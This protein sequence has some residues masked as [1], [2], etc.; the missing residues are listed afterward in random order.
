MP[1]LPKTK[2][3]FDTRHT[4]AENLLNQYEYPHEVLV[5]IKEF[6]KDY[7]T[8]LDDSYEER[9]EGVFIAKNATVWPGAIIVGPAIIGHYAEIR[10]GAFV[11]GSVIVGDGAIIGN[12]T[13]VKNSII[14]D[15]ATLPHYNYVGDSIIGFKAHMGAGAIASNLRLDKREIVLGIGKERVQ[16]KLRKIGAFLG[17]CAEVGCGSILCP[18]TIIGKGAVV[19][20]LMR[21]KGVVGENEIYKPQNIKEY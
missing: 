1:K 14:F 10:P 18:G 9:N 2:D 16:T 11:R 13:E 19:Y 20:P 7:S 5:F 3:L 15:N 12:S 4:I 21:V 8:T 17:D 6:I